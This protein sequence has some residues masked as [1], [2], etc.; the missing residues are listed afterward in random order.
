M[1]DLT[2]LLN[3]YLE[4]RVPLWLLADAL[5]DAGDPRADEVRRIGREFYGGNPAYWH[6]PKLKN[7]WAGGHLRER[8][9]NAGRLVRELL[10]EPCPLNHIPFPAC[11]GCAGRGWIWKPPG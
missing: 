5:T 1:L 9:E 3:G 8:R 6:V 2:S 11:S 7:P 4:S 10:T